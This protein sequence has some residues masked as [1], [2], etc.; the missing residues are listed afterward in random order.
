MQYS[1]LMRC[2]AIHFLIIIPVLTTGNTI[3]PIGIV[4][5]PVNCFL[6]SLIKG[7][8]WRPSQ[9]AINLG[10]IDGISSVM[11]R[12]VFDVSNQFGTFTGSPSK[13]LVHLSTQKPDKVYIF[14]FVEATNI[15][16][17]P[18]PAAVKDP[19]DGYGM[20]NDI[21]LVARI[22]TITI[23]R[24]WLAMDDVIDKQRYQFFRKLIRSVII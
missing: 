3:E 22:K 5:I 19:V 11:P 18:D 16:G 13:F 4:Q 23:N 10:S 6:Q 14:P 24:K 2:V 7:D 21:Q 17:L 8:G 1:S 12:S 20:I 9:L 15:I